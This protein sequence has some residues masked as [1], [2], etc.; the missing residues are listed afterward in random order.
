MSLFAP[1]PT[2]DRLERLDVPAD[3]FRK[4]RSAELQASQLRG[5][6]ECDFAVFSP[7]QS[8]GAMGECPAFPMQDGPLATQPNDG[9]VARGTVSLLAYFDSRHGEIGE[10]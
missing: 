10:T 2:R 4:G 6:F 9:R 7:A 1:L 5:I 8:C 3:Q